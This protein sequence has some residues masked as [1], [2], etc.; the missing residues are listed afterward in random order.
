MEHLTKD[1]IVIFLGGTNEISKNESKKGLR[2]IM[3]FTERS[4]NTNLILLEALHRY[5]LHYTSC[6]NAEVN[7]YNRR[8][9]SI[10]STA[11]HVKV[12]KASTERKHH[13]RH[14]LHLNNR[15]KDW[16]VYNIVNEIKTLNFF[17]NK[18]TTIE[19]PR[20]RNIITPEGKAP[21]VRCVSLAEPDQPPTR[22]IVSKKKWSYASQLD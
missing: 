18:P 19:L 14:G 3:A 15:G 10:M 20:S 21:P 1:D 5:N 2:S 22:W 8:L 16:I 7:F 11:S 4:T 9:Q 12:L 13:T 6:I 17:H